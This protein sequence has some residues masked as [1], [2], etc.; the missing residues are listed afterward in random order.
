[1]KVYVCLEKSKNTDAF[2]CGKAQVRDQVCLSTGQYVFDDAA[3]VYVP[4]VDAMPDGYSVPDLFKTVG[5]VEAKAYAFTCADGFAEEIDAEDLAEVR[6]F[7]N[8]AGD[9]VDATSIA[10]PGYTLMNI[11]TITPV[12]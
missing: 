5:M 9:S 3:L 4:G 12:V 6:L 1:M 7:I 10:Y 2:T 8:E 11:I